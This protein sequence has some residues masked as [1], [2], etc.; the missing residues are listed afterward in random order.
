MVPSLST[1][2][3]STTG[4]GQQAADLL[5]RMV[6]GETVAPDERIEVACQLILRQSVREIAP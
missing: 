1:I 4:L 6:E 2:Q 3:Q 5:I